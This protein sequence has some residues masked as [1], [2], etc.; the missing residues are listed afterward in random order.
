MLIAYADGIGTARLTDDDGRSILQH[1]VRPLA[2][3]TGAR[4]V[5]VEWPASLA[6]IGGHLSWAASAHHGV[7]H[8]D[9]LL[10][11]HPGERV[12]LLGYSGGCRVV[13]DWLDTRPKHRHRVAAV[14][15][16]SDPYRPYGRDQHGTR[17]AYGWGIA[18]QLLGPIPGRTFWSTHPEDAISNARSDS[19]LRT[20]ADLSD[21]IPGGLLADLIN[22]HQK[23]NWQLLWQLGIIRTNP[24]G[25]FGTLG[26]R[27]H[28]A[29]V[30]IDGYLHRGVHTTGYTQP[31]RTSDGKTESLAHRLAD[32]IAWAINHPKE[33]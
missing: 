1:V 23:G 4:P 28:Q 19:L 17:P 5:R 31:F 30:D 11:D 7:L 3:K 21:H 22:H 26:D 12:I 14:G 33:D 8:L 16:L 25:W 6:G 20:F 18:G 32:S 24:L 2:A 13:H 29:R 27:L 10:H 15:L 9:Q